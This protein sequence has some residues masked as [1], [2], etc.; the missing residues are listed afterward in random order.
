M[1]NQDGIKKDGMENPQE[2]PNVGE[3]AMTEQKK[4]MGFGTAIK[5]GAVLLG[6]AALTGLGWL[7]RGLIGGRDDDTDD[8][9]AIEAENSATE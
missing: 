4:K 9:P 5:V 6:G 1:A 7:L 3:P 8:T 2:N